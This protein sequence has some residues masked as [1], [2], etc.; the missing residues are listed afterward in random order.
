MGRQGKGPV[1]FEAENDSAFPLVPAYTTLRTTCP[2]AA[3]RLSETDAFDRL[4]PGSRIALFR[5]GGGG[6]TTRKSHLVRVKS[7]Q[8]T[9]T[10]TI[11]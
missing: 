6:P 8:T 9:S 3:W 5:F 7:N 2:H 11:L 4:L 1:L 10:A